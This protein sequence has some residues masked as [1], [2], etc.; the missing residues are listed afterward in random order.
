MLKIWP[1]AGIKTSKKSKRPAKWRSCSRAPSIRMSHLNRPYPKPPPTH[2]VSL[3]PP[4]SLS[5]SKKKKSLQR[6]SRTWLC[7]SLPNKKSWWEG[8]FWSFLLMQEA[9][10]DEAFVTPGWLGGGGGSCFNNASVL[11]LTWR[12]TKIIVS[13]PFLFF[14][15]IINSV[16]LLW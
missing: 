5:S 13:L 15:Q 10:D 4:S 1:A 2:P 16:Q 3:I 14:L 6:Q 8:I 9:C 12:P 7:V 11:K